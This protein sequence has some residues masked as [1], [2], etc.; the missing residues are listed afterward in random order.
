MHLY[1]IY[2]RPHYFVKDKADFPWSHIGITPNHTV[3]LPHGTVKGKIA[4]EFLHALG[5]HHEHVRHDRDQ[6]VAVR[7]FINSNRNIGIAR[8]SQLFK[9]L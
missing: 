3:N 9:S 8:V 7:E 5:L 6:Y 2:F 4:H 1:T